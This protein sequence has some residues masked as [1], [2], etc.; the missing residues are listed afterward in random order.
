MIG[1]GPGRRSKIVHLRNKRPAVAWALLLL[2]LFFT[3][4]GDIVANSGDTGLQA[5]K[6]VSSGGVTPDTLYGGPGNRHG[7]PDDFDSIVPPIVIWIHL[8][9]MGVIH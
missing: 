6:T 1:V 5:S 9:L 7:D 3:T 2:I 4:A 8:F